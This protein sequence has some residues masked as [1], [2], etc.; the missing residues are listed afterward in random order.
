MLYCLIK[1]RTVVQFAPSLGYI[2][3]YIYKCHN[4]GKK[5]VIW[6]D[7][8]LIFVQKNFSINAQKFKFYEKQKKVTEHL[9][10]SSISLFQLLIKISFF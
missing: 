10:K 2:Y 4:I 9:M 7:F 5:R 3:I 8:F 6:Q 1:K